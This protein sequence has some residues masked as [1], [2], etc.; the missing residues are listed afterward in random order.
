VVGA[1]RLIVFH[2]DRD[3]TVAVSNGAAIVS[4]ALA[5]SEPLQRTVE[6]G[7]TPNGHAYRRTRYRDAR[8]LDRIEQ[9][10]VHGAA[11]AWSGGD[12]AGSYTDPLGPDA[13]AAMLR[14][15]LET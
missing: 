12:A 1:S 10:T 6:D 5:R 7:S 2:G 3:H 13:S 9:W 4:A 8:G 15:F 11:H 14:F